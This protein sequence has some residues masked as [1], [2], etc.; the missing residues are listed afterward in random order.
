VGASEVIREFVS[1]QQPVIVLFLIL[2][3]GYVIGAIR[4]A[5]FAVGPIAGTLLVSI[6]VGNFGYRISEGA[7]S[8]GF[9]LFIFSV[10]YQAGPR[11][12]HALKSQG[13]QYA[14]LAVFVTG[15][16]FVT[17]WAAGRLLSLSDG[18]TAGLFAGA[19]TSTPTLA[20]AQEAVRSGLA[21]LPHGRTVQ[22]ALASIGTVYAM[23]YL[24]GTFGLIAL[25]SVFPRLI[26]VDLKAEARRLEPGSREDTPEPLQARAYRVENEEFC[27]SSVGE[28][29]QRYWDGLSLVRVRRGLTW[30]VLVPSERLARGDEIYAYG[31]AQFFRSGIEHA[32]P[33]IRILGEMEL[34]A[35]MTHVVVVRRAAVGKTLRELD[36]A[37]QHGLVVSAIT[38][39]GHP[40]PV[41]RDLQLERGDI[42]TVVGPVWGI[43]ALP[44]M[45]GPVESNVIET[46][47]TTFAFGVALG[48][49]L[50]LL[51]VTVGG[52][53]LS[54]GT[55]GG[56]LLAGIAAGWLNSARPPIAR[57][58]EAARW[59][60][61]EF[62]I[63]IFM[64]GVGLNAG[65][66][67]VQ[68]FREAGPLVL[69]AAVFVVSLPLLSGYVF[70]R[71]VLNMNPA[72][73]LGALAG[74]MTSAPA[75]GL[76]T[77]EAGSS[78][79]ALGYTGTYAFSCIV[80][81][82]AGTLIMFL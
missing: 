29:A 58:P 60:L 18:G 61:M 2:G 80:M 19:L 25:V 54:L 27:R 7:Q 34:S 37:R 78:V 55:A 57:F 35:S 52:I 68:S 72:L 6:V 10:G 64:A 38:R 41:G 70:G 20:A 50:G 32:G 48:A 15:I 11:F 1:S 53:P 36:L 39:D 5:G 13:L 23:T 44:E 46:D 31:Y 66:S 82:L 43:R 47:M 77:R 59:I 74:A 71:A 62:G 17:A 56:L 40:L 63:L 42:L 14:T 16:G 9:A 26:R 49:A 65:G 73:L 69:L 33:E 81:T 8:V 79:P 76:V 4:I 30:L 51:S 12:L 24:I 45:L 22:Q 3:F 75:L 67:I 28:L 21:S